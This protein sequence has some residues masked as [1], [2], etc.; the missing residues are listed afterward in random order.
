MKFGLINKKSLGPFVGTDFL[1]LM[2]GFIAVMLTQRHA[3]KGVEAVQPVTDVWP[4][5]AGVLAF[6][7][8]LSVVA[9]FTLKLDRQVNDEYTFQAMGNSA[10]SAILATFVAD[11]AMQ[12]AP[13]FGV[14]RIA[15]SSDLTLG[16]L[17]GSWAIGYAIHRIRG[18]V[19]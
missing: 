9:V 7:A 12:L 15:S 6:V 8:L 18:T 5:V 11:L 14:A 16:V 3:A 19:L 13:A 4:F 2:F 17:S 10:I 1:F